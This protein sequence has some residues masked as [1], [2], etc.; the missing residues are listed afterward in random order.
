MLPKAEIL[1]NGKDHDHDTIDGSTF[2]VVFEQ[3]SGWIVVF[4]MFLWELWETCASCR[5]GRQITEF[6][7]GASP[8]AT[9]L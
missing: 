5:L 4:A 6:I 7:T 2:G 3:V 8:I 9:S 1:G